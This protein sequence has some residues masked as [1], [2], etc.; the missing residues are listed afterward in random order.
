MS[1]I[2][3]EEIVQIPADLLRRF[4]GR[5]EVILRAVRELVRKHAHLYSGRNGKLGFHPLLHSSDFPQ[6]DDGILYI[7]LHHNHALP[8]VLHLI[9]RFDSERLVH[10]RRILLQL[11]FIHLRIVP[12]RRRH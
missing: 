5:K 10:R 3:H 12:C 6:P 9:G 2:Y 11:H 1:I 4:H 7:G 8:E